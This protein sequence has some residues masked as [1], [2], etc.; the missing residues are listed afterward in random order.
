LTSGIVTTG[1]ASGSASVSP[2]TTTSYSLN[3]NSGAFTGSVTVRVLTI[4]EV[5]PR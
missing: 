1:G 4:Q 3:C 5:P 2:A